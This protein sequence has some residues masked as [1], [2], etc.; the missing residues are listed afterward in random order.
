[1]NSLKQGEEQDYSFQWQPEIFQL[2]MYLKVQIQ[3]LHQD[4]SNISADL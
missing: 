1:M 4:K 3:V 2:K